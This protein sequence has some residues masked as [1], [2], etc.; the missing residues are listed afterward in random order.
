MQEGYYEQ[1]H[2]FMTN[3][4]EIEKF[5]VENSRRYRSFIRVKQDLYKYSFR[6]NGKQLVMTAQPKPFKDSL[7]N[8]T[9]LRMSSAT[10]TIQNWPHVYTYC[11][12]KIP[13]IPIPT[14]EDITKISLS[15]THYVYY[16]ENCPAGYTLIKD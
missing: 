2:K 13:N 10:G 12:S 3:F 5:S 16:L 6:A 11:E 9:F 7:S 1:H 14:D 4:A 8:T 15:K